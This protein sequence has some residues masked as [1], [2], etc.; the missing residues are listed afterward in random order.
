[1]QGQIKKVKDKYKNQL[2]ELSNNV[3][4]SANRY[5]KEYQQRFEELSKDKKFKEDMFKSLYDDFG[6]GVDDDDLF[7][8]TVDDYIF[9][10]AFD[11]KY[12]T[13][14]LKQARDDYNKA[15]DN[16]WNKTK[17]MGQE[18]FD[19]VGDIPFKGNLEIQSGKEA[20]SSYMGDSATSYI[21][22]HFDDYWVMDTKEFNDLQNSISVDDYNAW[23]KKQ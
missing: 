21:N 19:A 8:M 14:Q 23:A 17:E 20:I 6:V 7:N 22:R 12:D 16:Y 11:P 9:E 13:K 4:N 2:N 5:G 3:A 18:V 15:T 10:K 1:M